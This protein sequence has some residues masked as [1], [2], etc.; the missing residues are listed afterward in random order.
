MDRSTAFQI[1]GLTPAATRAD[2]DRAKRVLLAALHPDKHQGNTELFHRLTRDIL[3]AHRILT[4]SEGGTENSE[5]ALVRQLFDIRAAESWNQASSLKGT[6]L[7][8]FERRYAS[9]EILAIAILGIDPDVSYYRSVALTGSRTDHRG[10][11]LYLIA[12]NHTATRV[13]SLDVQ[14]GV[15]I[16]NLGH[17]YSSDGCFYWSAPDG[18]WHQHSSE[19][20]PRAKL[21]GFLIYPQLRSAASHFTRWF[22]AD[23]ICVTGVYVEGEY[24]VAL[25]EEPQAVALAAQDGGQLTGQ[26][27][28]HESEGDDDSDDDDGDFR[29]CDIYLSQQNGDPRLKYLGTYLYA[30][31]REAGYYPEWMD[32]DDVHYPGEIVIHVARGEEALGIAVKRRVDI[33][34]LRVVRQVPVRIEV[35]PTQHQRNVWIFFGD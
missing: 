24:D 25:P 27:H 26:N 1:L 32:L 22:L 16:D 2:I 11:S 35:D 12:Y 4:N 33:A 7:A 28:S 17:Q 29:F 8:R 3:A 13:T 6:M 30:S 5:P 21:D 20:A 15:L 23:K 14:R 34:L 19:L 10:T 18:T 31:L 9:D